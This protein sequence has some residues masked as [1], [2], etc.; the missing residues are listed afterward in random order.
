MSKLKISGII[1]LDVL[2]EEK[3]KKKVKKEEPWIEK[4]VKGPFHDYTKDPKAEENRS[5]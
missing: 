5:Y 4:F 2:K 1:S 3:P